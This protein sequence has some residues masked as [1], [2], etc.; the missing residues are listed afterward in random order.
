M[1]CIGANSAGVTL[2]RIGVTRLRRVLRPPT[3]NDS[4]CDL[5]L[6]GEIR[7]IASLQLSMPLMISS[8]TMFPPSRSF[9]SNQQ[10]VPNASIFSAIVLAIQASEDE[11]LKKT[12]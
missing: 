6:F 4:H 1:S 9:S 3:S 10:H 12:L 8:A 5:V 11:S 7:T 2:F